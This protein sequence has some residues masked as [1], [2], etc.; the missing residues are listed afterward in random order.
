MSKAHNLLGM[1]LIGIITC[2]M[3]IPVFEPQPEAG[4]TGHVRRPAKKIEKKASKKTL[5]PFPDPADMRA[6]SGKYYLK[7]SEKRA[8]PNLR[9]YNKVWIRVS[10][11]GSRAYVMSGDK[12][13]YTMYASA[14]AIKNGK[15][16]TP[17]GTYKI[18]EEGGEVFYNNNGVGARYYISY[19]DHGVY[20]FHSVPINN[21]KSGVKVGSYHY[22]YKG[23]THLTTLGKKPD[24][25][26]CVRLSVSDAKW[27]YE[28]RMNGGLPVGSRVEIKMK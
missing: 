7:S 20:L 14:G 8:Y 19:H 16:N 1:G 11:L 23:G 27:L 9:K 21:F 28:Q 10:V 5:L 22:G 4:G 13:V 17:V 25:H 2:L 12:P 26:G 6:M 3:L 18:Q 24:S 15:S